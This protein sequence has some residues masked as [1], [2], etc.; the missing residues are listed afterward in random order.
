MNSSMNQ[1][2]LLNSRPIGEPKESDFALVETPIPEPGEGE[3]LNRTIYLS[4]DPYMRGRMSDRA[5][6]AAAV[7]LGSVMVGGTVS[8]VMK[9]NHPQFS[10]GDFVL[11]YDGWQAY[12]ISRGETLRKLDPKEAPLSY[13]LGVTGMPGMTAYFAL[14]DVGQPQA[15]ETVVVSAAS[16]AVGAVA[17][18]IAL[19]KGLRVVGVAGSDAKCDYVVK[20]LGFDACINRKT[21]DLSSALKATC[22]KGID[23]YFDNTAGSILEAVLQ[24]INQGA[25]IPL[26]GLISQYNAENLPPGP[27]LMP[28]LIKR[29]LIKGFLVSDYQHRH[30]EFVK[31]VSSWLQEGK[32]K[33]KEDVVQK[34]ENAPHAFMG[35]L[36]GKNFGKLIVQV[37]SDPTR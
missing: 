6:Y 35:L 4:L 11:G 36:Q 7:E 8:Q 16:G 14:L 27:N 12:G 3:V 1:Q 19:I 9:S 33:Y 31:D 37:S 23:V 30:S 17:G 18:Q 28:L 10:A 26:V 25:R 29:A 13:A 5:S 2:I 21:Q 20:E 34:L 22:P 24:Q 32:L 15:G